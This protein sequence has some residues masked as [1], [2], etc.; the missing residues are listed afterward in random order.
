MQAFYTPILAFDIETVP[1]CAGVRLLEDLPADLPDHQV[2]DLAFAAQREKTQSDFLP[3]YLQKVVAIACVLRWFD[4]K[5]SQMRIHAASLGKPE[6]DEAA[7]IAAFFDLIERFN[8]QL[9]SWNGGG[10]DLPTLH[11]RALQ[12]GISAP[13]YWDN[14]VFN[15]DKKWNFYTNRYHEQHIDLMDVLSMYQARAV[16]PLDKMAKL[17][18][19]PG[20]MGLDGGQVWQSFCAGALPEIRAYCETDAANTYLLFLRFQRMRGH[21]SAD[22]YQAEMDLFR[23]YLQ[24]QSKHEHS[25]HWQQFLDLWQAHEMM[26]AKNT[27]F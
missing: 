25:V 5:N 4:K 19:F 7:L 10:F 6:D 14:G 15:R 2:A 18:G 22:K 26:I 27:S 12:H 16:A 21:L 1:D 3:H 17:C 23:H 13:N 8:P 20:K 11:Y 9:V 24:T